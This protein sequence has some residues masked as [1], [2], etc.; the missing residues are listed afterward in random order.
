VCGVNNIDVGVFS[1]R[2]PLLFF[3]VVVVVV[4]LICSAAAEPFSHHGIRLGSFFCV[5][6]ILGLKIKPVF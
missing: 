5:T 2:V 1:F 6:P 3:V 4:V